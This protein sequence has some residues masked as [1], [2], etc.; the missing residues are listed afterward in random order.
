MREKRARLAFSQ[1]CSAF[2]SVCSFRLRIISLMLS[3]SAAIS[4]EASTEIERVRSP[5]VTAVATSAIERTW[6]VRFGA[7]LFTLAGRAAPRARRAG[8][9]SLAAETP[10]D[11]HFSGHVGHLVAEGRKR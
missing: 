3:F 4:P 7:S 1:S 2:L 8:H 5:L 9:A 11:A 6:L 10:F